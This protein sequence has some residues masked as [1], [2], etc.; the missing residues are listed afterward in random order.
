M[1]GDDYNAEA[2][3][4]VDEVDAGVGDISGEG[5]CDLAA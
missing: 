3:N 2:N 4:V 1:G 5:D